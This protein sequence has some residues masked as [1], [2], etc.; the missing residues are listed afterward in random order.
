MPFLKEHIRKTWVQVDAGEE[1]TI[2]ADHGNVQIVSGKNGIRF[3]VK[4]ELLSDSVPTD[5][6]RRPVE[7]TAIITGTKKRRSRI[8]VSDDSTLFG[9]QNK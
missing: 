5:L 7:Q 2:I 1:V 6:P 9:G 3:P 4:T 8:L